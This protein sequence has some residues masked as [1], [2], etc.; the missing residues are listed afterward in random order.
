MGG[1]YRIPT[2][3]RSKWDGFGN[4]ISEFLSGS[5]MFFQTWGVR[6]SLVSLID[7]TLVPH[8]VVKWCLSLMGSP[9]Y[10]ASLLG[11]ALILG[12]GTYH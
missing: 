8:K 12:L 4:F 9:T 1:P 11:W 2:S 5:R 6:V 10:Q 3:P 7:P